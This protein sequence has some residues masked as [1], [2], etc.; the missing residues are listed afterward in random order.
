MPI[1]GCYVNV[2]VSPAMLVAWC[3]YWG[4]RKL[5][6][7]IK[8]ILTLYLLCVC[9]YLCQE[10][11]HICKSDQL[12]NRPFDWLGIWFVELFFQKNNS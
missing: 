4:S 11:G 3:F 6:S 10:N 2:V 1:L 12:T 7:I 8:R 5:K 9:C